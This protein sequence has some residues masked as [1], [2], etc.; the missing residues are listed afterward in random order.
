[1][2][3]RSV[4]VSKPSTVGF[5][6]VELMVSVS[7]LVILM[8][9]VSNFIGLVQ[10]TWVRSNSQVA[11]FRE[12]RIAFEHLSKTITQATLNAY[13]EAE[14]EKV[15]KDNAGQDIMLANRFV[16]QSELQFVCGPTPSLLTGA[17]AASYPGHGV[18]F[19]APL[20]MTSLVDPG[21]G[22]DVANTENMVNLMCG[23]G[24][25]VAWGDDVNFRPAFLAQLQGKVPTRYRLRLMEYSP[26]AEQNLIYSPEYRPITAH[27]KQWFAD[28]LRQQVSS[29]TEDAANRAFT[30]PIAENILALI[31]S[32]QNH[33]FGA[34]GAAATAI[35]PN[36][37]H[38]S[39]LL[40]NPGANR[41][42]TSPQGT[43]HL[44]PPL[45]KVT[46]VAL[47]HLAG[48]RLSEN[49]G[50]RDEV[51]GEVGGLFQTAAN[52]QEDL[53][54][55]REEPSGLKSLLIQ[56]KLNYRVFTTTLTLKQ[57]RWSY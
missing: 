35:A 12:A 54:G 47:D 22:T 53:E 46:M 5:T 38:D 42:S 25:F 6:L 45:L 33:S 40:V 57:A 15:G 55:T 1:M 37:I 7:I 52:F 32:P 8:L 13:W 26:T 44:M 14:T 9:V 2:R 29:G 34:T 41:D 20:G 51:L 23:R 28:A 50:L 19:Q 43:Q 49:S 36:Y 56:K 24:Y 10:R 11:Q 4:H 48:Q 21:G 18:F 3:T 30:R 39:T 17:V 27:S 31:I 16:R